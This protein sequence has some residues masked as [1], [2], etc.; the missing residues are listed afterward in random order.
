M[1][2]IRPPLLSVALMVLAAISATAQDRTPQTRIDTISGRV[3]N[4]AGQPLSGVSVSLDVMGGSLGQ[5]TSTDSEGNF[6]VQGLDSGIYRIYLRAPGYVTYWP[7]PL[8][9]TYRPGDKVELSLIK[10]A[11]ISGTVTRISGEPVVLVQVRAFQIRDAEGNRVDRPYV[12]DQVFTD[13]RGYYRIWALP[14]GTYVIAAGG[15]GQYFGSVNPFANDVMTYAPA[16]TRDTAAEIIARSSQETTVDIH[17]RSEPGHVVSG[18]IS[19]VM[20]PMPFNASVRLLDPDSRMIVNSATALDRTFQINGVADGEYEAVAIGGG[21]G[22]SDLL[23]SESRRLTIRGADVTGL[24]LALAPMAAIEA[25]VSLEADQKLNCGRRRESAVRETMLRLLRMRPETK[26]PAAKDKPADSS[27]TASSPVSILEMVPNDK[28]DI[29][30]RSLSPAP[31]RFEVRLPAAG[32]YLKDLSLPKPGVNLARNGIALKQGERV[33][34]VTVAVAEG[35]ASLRGR[36]SLAEGQSAPP[37]LRIYLVPA[38]REN[39]DNPLRFFEAG[40]AADATFA[41]GNIAPGK[42]WLWAQVVESIDANTPK[43][44]RT[45]NDLR[46]KLLKDAAALNKEISFKP[47]ERTVDYEFPYPASKP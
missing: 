17:Y 25:H 11:V 21:T 45:N 46:A 20:P 47:C 4:E 16:S 38:E 24:D 1:K 40:V 10:G 41:I 6:K 3:V 8:A 2:S 34:G 32:W 27:A 5:R 28:G 35:G 18:K 30:F 33:S 44:P 15:A 19:G 29:R 26:P 7:S 43:S 13:D 31:Y 37:N 36:L 42:Y 12:S 39:A 23:S 14:P 9:P 22:G